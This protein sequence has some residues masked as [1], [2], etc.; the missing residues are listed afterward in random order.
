MGKC[1][2]RV[3]KTNSLKTNAASHNNTSWYTDMYGFLK[4]SPSGGC[5]NYKWLTLQKIIPIYGGVPL[6]FVFN[7]RESE[8]SFWKRKTCSKCHIKQEYTEVQS[9]KDVLVHWLKLWD[10]GFLTSR[11]AHPISVMNLDGCLTKWSSLIILQLNA[12]W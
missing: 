3:F 10:K 4:H 8:E 6:M 1:F 2:E 12:C 7:Y 9:Q 11:D 5:L